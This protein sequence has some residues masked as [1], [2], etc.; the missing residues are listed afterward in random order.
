[1]DWD[2]AVIV[3]GGGGGVIGDLRFSTNTKL[4]WTFIAFDRKSAH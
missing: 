1:M 3:V 2:A 4:S